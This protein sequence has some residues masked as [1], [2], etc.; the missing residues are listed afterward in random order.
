[1]SVWKQFC[2]AVE[3][4]PARQHLGDLVPLIET[5]AVFEFS[6]QQL[7]SALAYEPPDGNPAPMFP[8]PRLTCAG[9][10]GVI[11]LQ[12]PVMDLET[13]V[14]EYEVIAWTKN[15]VQLATC[16][17]EDTTIRAHD[18]R[19]VIWL[20]DGPKYFDDDNPISRVK[21]SEV[22]GLHAQFTEQLE[23][24]KADLVGARASG[25]AAKIER[26]EAELAACAQ[27]LETTKELLAKLEEAEVE[28]VTLSDRFGVVT[29]N[30]VRRHFETAL[31]ALHWINK[32]DHYTVE[33]SPALPKK[34]KKRKK[35]RIARLHER[36]RY[37]L[38]TKSEV[39]EAWRCAHHVGT[40]SSPMPHLR[41][42][43]YKTLRAARYGENQGK[44][45][46]VRATHVNGKC[47]EW[48]DGDVRYKVM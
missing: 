42:G 8:F 19:G 45:I 23:H 2:R 24:A 3:S 10:T 25:H 15:V 35:G 31:H 17:L 40:H 6:E 9:P 16:E 4:K 43:H 20:K 14:L 33:V 28:C 22:S 34:R 47:V 41:R 30:V 5:S 27:R 44:R 29:L 38:L 12:N 13:G 11:H 39:T 26:A 18:V 46:W 48:R 1:M 37:I 32:P 7:E 21:P 36:P